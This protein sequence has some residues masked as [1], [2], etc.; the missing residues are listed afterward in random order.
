MVHHRCT[1]IAADE[2]LAVVRELNNN[3]AVGEQSQPLAG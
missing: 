2:L 1:K 3:R